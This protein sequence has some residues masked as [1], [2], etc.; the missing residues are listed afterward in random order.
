MDTVAMGANRKSVRFTIEGTDLMVSIFPED[1]EVRV[2]SGKFILDA[3]PDGAARESGHTL[4]IARGDD[5]PRARA[6]EIK[7]R[8]THHI[9]LAHEVREV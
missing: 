2:T 7:R 3:D 1:G 6:N 9:T 8:P 4:V 5:N